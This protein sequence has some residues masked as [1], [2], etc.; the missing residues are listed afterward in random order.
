MWEVEPSKR[1]FKLFSRSAKCGRFNYDLINGANFPPFFSLVVLS[2]FSQGAIFPIF[3]T[4]LRVGKV[5]I[6]MH[7]E[8]R[9]LA[10]FKMWGRKIG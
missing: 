10:S 8:A 3:Q 2:R 4:F 5:G 6:R 7:A 9:K 1:K